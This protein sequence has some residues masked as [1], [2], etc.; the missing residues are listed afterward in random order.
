MAK[1]KYSSTILD[2]GTSWRRGGGQLQALAALPVEKEP[3]VPIQYETGEPQRQPGLFGVEKS[4]LPV[5]YRTAAIQ[6][7]PHR[8]TNAATLALI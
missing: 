1:L 8:C 3:S 5:R 4:L 7:V 6:P 2:L